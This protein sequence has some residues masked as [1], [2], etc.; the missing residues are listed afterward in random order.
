LLFGFVVNFL[1]IIEADVEVPEHAFDRLLCFEADINLGIYPNHRDQLHMMAGY[2]EEKLNDLK[3]VVHS[4]S[5]ISQLTDKVFKEMVWVG[6]GCALIKRTV[7]EKILFV[8]DLQEYQRGLVC[9]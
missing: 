8:Y 5:D 6:I 3:P 4:V 2:F 1:W 7:F 9:S